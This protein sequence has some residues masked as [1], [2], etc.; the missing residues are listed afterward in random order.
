MQIVGDQ[1]CRQP[2]QA[3]PLAHHLVHRF[4][5]IADRH[6]VEAAGQFA[7][8]DFLIDHAAHRQRFGIGNGRDL[9][10][11][12]AA[13]AARRQAKARATRGVGGGDADQ[14][15][16]PDRVELVAGLVQ[17]H[18]Q[19]G[20]AVAQQKI[21]I[22]LGKHRHRIVHGEGR[23]PRTKARGHRIVPQRL[24]Q[25]GQPR[26]HQRARQRLAGGDH[27]G[28][29]IDTV[30][31]PQRQPRFLQRMQ[32]RLRRLQELPTLGG[33]P[34]RK[35]AAI[36]QRRAGPHFDRLHAAA[37]RRWG[38]VAQFGGAGEAAGL[39]QTDKVF[40]PT[41]MHGQGAVGWCR[42]R[43]AARLPCAAASF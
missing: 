1:P 32:R 6:H 29:G 8:G 38:D 12:L 41:D 13:G 35:H 21:G 27:H 18:R 16:D 19:V 37:E 34:D 15:F 2:G 3:H 17:P 23:Q 10:A 40:E 5:E 24:A 26:R 39:G 9:R 30:G 25:P 36:D 43:A 7:P 20:R 4:R 22:A 28:A 33:Q 31:R 42:G 14:P 11:A